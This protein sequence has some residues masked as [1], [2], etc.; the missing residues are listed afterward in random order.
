MCRR[1][2]VHAGGGWLL[3]LV[4]QHARQ[5]CVSLS[6]ASVPRR[7]PEDVRR[8]RRQEAAQIARPALG[9]QQTAAARGRAPVPLPLP[10]QGRLQKRRLPLSNWTSGQR[11]SNRLVGEMYF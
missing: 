10:Q 2:R 1:K 9:A 5:F 11:L 8:Q 3:T 7:G 6:V 4:R